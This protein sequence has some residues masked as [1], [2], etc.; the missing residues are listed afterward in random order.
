MR[1]ALKRILHWDDTLAFV[2]QNNSVVA[3]HSVSLRS[4]F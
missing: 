2:L 1:K 3:L 4:T